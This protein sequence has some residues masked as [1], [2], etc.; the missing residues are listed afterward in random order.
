[1]L[2]GQTVG[3]VR[4]FALSGLALSPDGMRAAFVRRDL[5]RTENT[6]VWLFDLLRGDASP[7]TYRPGV[8]RSPI[9]SSD[10]SRIVFSSNRNGPFDLYV[11][12]ADGSA[13]EELLLK[14]GENKTAT[15]WSRDGHFL[16]YT[17]GSGQTRSEIWLLP[18]PGV[19][20]VGRKPFQFLQTE[21]A[22]TNAQFS[23][24]ATGG[25]KGVSPR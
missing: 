4:D 22:E 15:S 16:L 24:E 6:N 13:D 18:D 1:M 17:Q 11:K 14:S 10:G 5:Q 3:V 12:P 25:P 20:V 19:S 2:P 9:C 21:F 8:E 23:P 7:F